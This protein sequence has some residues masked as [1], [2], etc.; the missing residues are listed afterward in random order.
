MI[1]HE[2]LL[3]RSVN[4]TTWT[5]RQDVRGTQ[6]EE[7]MSFATLAR[8]K[9]VTITTFRRTG[10]PVSTPIWIVP[11]PDGQ[12]LYGFSGAGAG[13]IK[14]L[15]RNPSVRVA[16]CDM[17]GRPYGPAREGVGM[18]L[19]ESEAGRIER[20]LNRKYPVAGR[21]LR[22]YGWLRGRKGR[23]AYFEIRFRDETAARLIR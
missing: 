22:W 10:E 9:Y 19:P 18:V 2:A 15:G 6:M 3:M 13:K 23:R 17:R 12:K 8:A 11:D 5:M 1:K 14:R 16:P 20:L 4:L 7:P 21:L